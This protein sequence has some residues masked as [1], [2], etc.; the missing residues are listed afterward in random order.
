MKIFSNIIIYLIVFYNYINLIFFYV[1]YTLLYIDYGKK[2]D[3]NI[4]ITKSYYY[5][6]FHT[7]RNINKYDY[8]V[9]LL[10]LFL[11]GLRLFKIN[12]INNN[13]IKIFFIGI[14]LL[15]LLMIID[16]FDAFNWYLD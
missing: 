16:P 6:Y 12:L 1:I 2:P 9:F 10:G 7:I 5:K 13:Q 14:L 15:A 4:L 11:I 8:F 3:D